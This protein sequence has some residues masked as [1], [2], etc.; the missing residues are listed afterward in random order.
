M[1]IAQRCGHV[2]NAFLPPR[3]GM[4]NLRSAFHDN[5]LWLEEIGGVG[6]ICDGMEGKGMGWL[7][8]NV[9]N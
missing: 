5:E 7:R 9:A 6:W 4:E 2:K 1:Q 3:N 8:T